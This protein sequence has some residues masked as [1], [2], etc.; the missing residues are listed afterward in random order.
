MHSGGI[1]F[2]YCFVIFCISYF[3]LTSNTWNAWRR[4]I[5]VGNEVSRCRNKRDIANFPQNIGQ[6]PKSKQLFGIQV[7]RSWEKKQAMQIKLFRNQFHLLLLLCWL[8]EVIPVVVNPPSQRLEV[9]TIGRAG[10]QPFQMFHLFFNA[11]DKKKGI[12]IPQ[13]VSQ[14]SNFGNSYCPNWI[15]GPWANRN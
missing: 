15:L 10:T 6:L 2:F 9:G 14:K 5:Y 3:L 1:Y 13:T 4:Y 7:N 12:Y 11:R 8:Q